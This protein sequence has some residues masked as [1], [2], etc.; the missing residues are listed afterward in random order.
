MIKKVLSAALKFKPN[1]NFSHF[2]GLTIEYAA[3]AC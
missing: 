2:R 3:K 1:V